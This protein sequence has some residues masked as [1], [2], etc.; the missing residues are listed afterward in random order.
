[1]LFVAAIVAA[2]VNLASASNQPAPPDGTYTYSILKSGSQIGASTVTVRRAGPNITI[3]ETQTMG[4]LTFVVDETV[5]AST[6]APESYVAT[7][8]KN[9]SS[10]TAR[11]AFD[12]TGA[13]VSFDGISGSQYFPLTASLDN[14]YVLESS[15]VTGLFLL[16]AQIHASRATQFL[17]IVPSR[18][19]SLVSHVNAQAV[20]PRPGI[21]AASD[22]S[23]SIASQVNF[24]EWY[25]PNTYVLDCVSVPIQDVLIKLTK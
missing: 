15:I 12:R 11:A 16:P 13:T 22:A 3:H 7:Y 8:T 18:V 4:D 19:S 1:M 17:Q 10:Q 20:G 24:D 6:L 23:L 25:N 9:G 2:A 21:I 5:Q 14:A